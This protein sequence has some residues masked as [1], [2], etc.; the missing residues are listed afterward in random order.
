MGFEG[1]TN[2]SAR[3]WWASACKQFRAGV[4]CVEGALSLEYSEARKYTA[5]LRMVRR[6]EH[7]MS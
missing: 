7:C 1:S 5:L 3:A 4:I 2:S 6:S